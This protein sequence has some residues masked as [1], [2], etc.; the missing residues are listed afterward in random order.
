MN[1]ALPQTK[2]E[3]PLRFPFSPPPLG[4][5]KLSE[6]FGSNKQ[7]QNNNL[8]QWYKRGQGKILNTMIYLVNISL[9][10]AIYS[11]FLIE[12]FYLDNASFR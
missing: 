12:D 9:I 1:I 11:L 2:E 4:P 10:F 3:R 5:V 7:I 8:S 6:T